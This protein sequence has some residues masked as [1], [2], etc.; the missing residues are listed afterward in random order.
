[1]IAFT[2]IKMLKDMFYAWCN[3]Q[4]NFMQLHSLQLASEWMWLDF[5]SACQKR[6]CIV[7][8]LP[9]QCQKC[10]H[11]KLDQGI[12]LIDHYGKRDKVAQN[13][14][15]PYVAMVLVVKHK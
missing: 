11:D 15:A 8:L 2:I 13:I 1:M 5:M 3:N 7:W 9:L 6:L 4:C 14:G 10:H 12:V